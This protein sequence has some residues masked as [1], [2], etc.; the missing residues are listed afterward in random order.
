MLLQIPTY[1]NHVKCLYR[2]E[3]E[4]ERETKLKNE[5]NLFLAAIYKDLVSASASP[6]T[7]YVGLLQENSIVSLAGISG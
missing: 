4:R 5:Y 3:R 2:Q 1:Q 7:L 6:D